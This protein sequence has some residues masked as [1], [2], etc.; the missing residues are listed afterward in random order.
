MNSSNVT[1]DVKDDIKSSIE[2]KKCDPV[3]GIDYGTTNTVIAE[4]HTVELSAPV[5]RTI[6]NEKTIP[7]RLYY[8]DKTDDWFFGHSATN[9]SQNSEFLFHDI[10]RIIGKKLCFSFSLFLFRSYFKIFR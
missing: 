7:T 9:S 2:E 3:R 4:I 10:K 5:I 6:D 1:D 8:D